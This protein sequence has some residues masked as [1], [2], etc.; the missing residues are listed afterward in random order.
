MEG[1]KCPRKDIYKLQKAQSL[2]NELNAQIYDEVI[3]ICTN[4]SSL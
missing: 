4:I 3:T 1:T 2:D